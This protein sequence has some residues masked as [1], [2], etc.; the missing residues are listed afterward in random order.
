[1]TD[2][3]YQ[4]IQC[5]NG[6]DLQ[7]AKTDLHKRLACPVCEIHFV[8]EEAKASLNQDQAGKGENSR[9]DDVLIENQRP[10]EAP[11]VTIWKL[12]CLG[13][14]LAIWVFNLVAIMSFGPS[15][16]EYISQNGPLAVVLS[17]FIC[18]GFIA[19]PAGIVLNILWVKKVFVDISTVGRF[20][21]LSPAVAICLSFIPVFGNTF[22]IDRLSI[23]M[24]RQGSTDPEAK[25]RIQSARTMF[26]TLLA[27]IVIAL[28]AVSISGYQTGKDLQKVSDKFL[29]EIESEGEPPTIADLS[30]EQ[31]A[32]LRMKVAKSLPP[33]FHMTFALA[34]CLIAIVYGFAVRKTEG[35]LYYTPTTLG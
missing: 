29:A 2:S 27:A 6:H 5:P 11:K 33:H 12:V 32:K 21:S 1:M 24:K 18:L 13:M 34:P 4:L 25:K 22:L 23:A 35:A 17:F 26:F 28:A 30:P 3:E 10:L 16:K 15:A 9:P 8:P 7:A 20:K 14:I 19:I 31:L